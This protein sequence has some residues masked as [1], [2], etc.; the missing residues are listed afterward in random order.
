RPLPRLHGLRV[1]LPV[2][3]RL[4]PPDRVDARDGRAPVRALPVRTPR[5]FAAL[6]GSPLPRPDAS[7]P[8]AGRAEQARPAATLARTARRHRPALARRRAATGA[9]AGGQ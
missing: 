3:R 5:P 8:A 4:R 9:D 1:L 6:P 2:R 7:G